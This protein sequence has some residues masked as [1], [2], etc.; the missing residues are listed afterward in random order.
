[1]HFPADP[2]TFSYCVVD[3]SIVPF[4]TIIEQDDDRDV[5]IENLPG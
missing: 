3:E 1:V 5:K 2:V 4:P